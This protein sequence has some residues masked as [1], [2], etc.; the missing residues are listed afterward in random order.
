[1]ADRIHYR[2]LPGHRRGFFRSSSAWLGPDYLLAVNSIRFR[3]EYKRYYFRDIQAIIVAGR[4][5]FHLSTRAALLG[6]LWLIAFSISYRSPQGPAL[7]GAAGITLVGIWL[8]ISTACSCTFRIYTAASGDLL[9]SVYRT[10]VARQFLRAIEPQISAAQVTLEWQSVDFESVHIGPRE[11]MVPSA[12]SQSPPVESGPSF[13]PRGRSNSFNVLLTALFADAL[14]HWFSLLHAVPWTSTISN[15]LAVFEITLA[16]VLLVQYRR[17]KVSSAQQKL[18]IATLVGTGLIFYGTMI[19]V[20]GLASLRAAA[21][22]GPVDMQ[23]AVR[24][25]EEINIGVTLALGLVGLAIL[26]LDRKTSQEPPSI[27]P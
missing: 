24:V 2:K 4:P 22:K 21:V 20:A 5:R 12:A 19:G 26:F 17:K 11:T 18:A 23:P 25:A 16:I 1:M 6:F 8:Y 7:V 27:I 3:E 15:V 10:W 14:W 9:P 13:E